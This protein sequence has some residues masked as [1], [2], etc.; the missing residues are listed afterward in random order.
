[1]AES[2]SDV[3]SKRTS[4]PSKKQTKLNQ[5]V[6]IVENKKLQ[7]AIEKLQKQNL[8]LQKKQV[9]QDKANRLLRENYADEY[10]RAHNG[11]QLSDLESEDDDTPSGR[12]S[13]SSSIQSK[14][15]ISTPPRK[16]RKAGQ[17]RI[18]ASPPSPELQMM[19][20]PHIDFRSSSFHRICNQKSSPLPGDSDSLSEVNNH[21][22][23]NPT[24]L[25]TATVQHSEPE[26]DPNSSASDNP[27]QVA[28]SKHARSP[29]APTSE[30]DTPSNAKKARIAKVAAG[31]KGVNQC[32]YDDTEVERTWL[33]EL[34]DEACEEF[35]EVYELTRAHVR[36]AMKS[37]MKALV[38]ATYSFA[39]STK[40]VTI[41]QNKKKYVMLA[42][43]GA[44]TCKEP[45]ALRRR[46]KNR[47][48][49]MV[50]TEHFFGHSKAPGIIWEDD[51]A[52]VKV[53]TLALVMTIL[54][55]C[56]EEWADGTFKAQ[57]L[58]DITQTP[59]YL[60]HLKDVKA[61]CSG[62]ATV[63]GNIC[64]LWAMKG[65]THADVQPKQISDGFIDDAEKERLVADLQGRTGET[66]S[67][68]EADDE[69]EGD[70]VK[71]E[72]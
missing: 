9:L 25:Q 59:Q 63:T 40:K 3:P 31:S 55:H 46:F 6:S 64:R 2:D 29:Q 68:A 27:V 65:R 19:E 69:E 50:I 37:D 43:C 38:V 54:E 57:K 12:L 70:I 7:A 23:T 48:I 61:W 21:F 4:R 36:G 58:N 8:E 67:E 17:P 13:F 47:I 33:Q 18:P 20:I 15:L 26:R 24:P 52:D 1:M 11:C 35:G 32:D 44:F 71:S 72:E 16:L 34:S 10:S 62:D 14:G 30:S 42:T 66:D 51:F 41:E 56:I 49:P 60:T 28:G 5:N 39:I 22:M 45:K 53:E